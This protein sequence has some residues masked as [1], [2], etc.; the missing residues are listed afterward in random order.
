MPLRNLTVYSYFSPHLAFTSRLAHLP[1]IPHL[2]LTCPSYPSPAYLIP[3]FVST[4]PPSP[5][6]A[7][8]L[9]PTS[10]L[11]HS[12][13]S[14][15]FHASRCPY[16]SNLPTVRIPL[17]LPHLHLST[18]LTTCPHF[19]LTTPP[20][21]LPSIPHLVHTSPISF[22]TLSPPLHLAHYLLTLYLT[23]STCSL[24]FHFSPVQPNYRLHTSSFTS[25]PLPGNTFLPTPYLN[26]ST[27][28]LTFHFSPCQHL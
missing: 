7:H 16:L 13:C 20:V 11:I 2:V 9:L 8:T 23:H 25:S 15:T 22:L 12:T 18:L 3:S 19:T 6:P 26:H 1:S 28:P 14:L 27:C 17:F 5:L 24:A 10:C 4:C 21:H